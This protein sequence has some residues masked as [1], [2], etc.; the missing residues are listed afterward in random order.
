ML[1]PRRAFPFRAT[2]RGLL[3][4][5]LYFAL[6]AGLFSSA[7]QGPDSR[8]IGV[9]GDPNLALWFM[10]WTPFALTHHLNPLFT[11][12]LDY[13]GGVN[14]MWNTAAP[15]LGLLFWPITETLGP[16]VAYNAAETLGLAL[17][18]WAAYLAFSRFVQQ[19]IAAWLG[20]LLY[21]FSPYMMSHALGQPPLVML[22]TPPLMLLAADQILVRQRRNPILVGSLL[23]LLGAVQ[24]LLWEELLA[25][26]AVLA[27]AGVLWLAARH[28]E[29]IAARVPY[30]VRAAGAA[31]AV[32][33]A[34]AAVPL[35]F[36]FLGPRQVHGAVWAPNQFV[37]DLL[38]F[39]TPTRLQALAP[40]AA[41]HISDQ[42]RSGVYE[43]G[44]YVGIPLLALL[45]AG[46]VLFRTHA[47]VRLTAALAG[48]IALLSMGPLINVIGRTT[49]VPVSLLAFG[50]V[51]A[52][53]DVRP[54][55]LILYLFLGLWIALAL[56][57]IVDDILP[58]RL[59]LFVFLFGG[60]LLA[61]IVDA[62]WRI[63]QRRRM[64]LLGS[65]GLLALVSLFPRLPYPTTTVDSPAF[66]ASTSIQQ[67]PEGSVALVAPYAYDWR[68]SVPMLWQVQ[69][70]MRFR[71]P[72][73]FA[74]IPGPSYTP[75]PSPLGDVMTAIARG[76]VV[77]AINDER[78]AAMR[79]DL[80]Q[81]QVGT[82]IVGPM[83]RQDQMVAIFTDLLN[84]SPEFDGGV[85]VWWRVPLQRLS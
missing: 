37:A 21:G 83:A 27:L 29:A 68:L 6:S 14:L 53:R 82:V 47:L 59:S 24:L 65:L 30:A 35:G 13:P 56:V 45:V 61:L 44:S 77:P 38:A 19:P 81:W 25:A 20:G 5:L 26:E 73:G 58:S 51:P 7:W 64:A 10:R 79:R 48:F 28:R 18:A 2:L 55:R 32:F 1:A 84:A 31:T 80:Q 71:M 52:T 62:A 54:A 60:L 34:L 57:P 36:Q 72:E 8:L 17:S 50:L 39:I 41:I 9:G 46:V 16:V 85:Y 33:L 63:R 11:D 3:A 70:G 43:W 78:R 49:P 4:L 75:P 66:F 40:Q 15:L 22:F 74:W 12:Y 67:I 76:T 42:F 69:S 23:G